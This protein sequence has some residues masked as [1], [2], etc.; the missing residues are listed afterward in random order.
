MTIFFAR[1]ALIALLKHWGYET[2]SG[3]SISALRDALRS[4]EKPE[5]IIADNQLGEGEWGTEAI[6]AV[7]EIF[8]DENIPGIV[9]TGDTSLMLDGFVNMKL[10]H[11]PLDPG[12]LRNLLAKLLD[13][14]SSSHV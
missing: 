8:K 5:L 10:M 1:E 11:K 7:R 13:Q 2:V 14:S 3:E 9:I 12:S 4:F 6:S